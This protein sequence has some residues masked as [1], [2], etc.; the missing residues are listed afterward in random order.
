MKNLFNVATLAALL[1]SF[2]TFAEA[3]KTDCTAMSDAG[4]NEVKKVKAEEK[5]QEKKTKAQ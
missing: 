2:N 1:I 5:T 4:R 3:A